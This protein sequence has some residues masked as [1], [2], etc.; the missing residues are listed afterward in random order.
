MEYPEI[1]NEIAALAAAQVIRMVE[2]GALP[3][4]DGHSPDAV[5]DSII[6]GLAMVIEQAPQCQA[7]SALRQ[8]SEAYGKLLVHYARQF[9]EA[10]K[11]SG[12]HPIMAVRDA[13]AHQGR[14]P[15]K[16]N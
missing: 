6:L 7:Q 16:L 3:G 2:A 9:R 13:N 15:S 5:L 14:A 11:E 10:F 12:V 8:T 1:D 4:K